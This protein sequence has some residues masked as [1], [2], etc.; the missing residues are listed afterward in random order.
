[1]N[2]FIVDN[3]M[4]LEFLE[5]PE[6]KIPF[7]SDS[8]INKQE[9]CKL[10]ESQFRKLARKYHPD[11]GGTNNDFKLLLDYKNKLLEQD[12]TESELLLSFNDSRFQSFDSNSMASKVG[13]QIFDLLS[14]WQEELGIKPLHRPKASEDEYEWIFKILDTELELCLNV[15]N[16]SEELAELSHDLYKDD[17][18]SI[19]V[20]LFFPSKKLAITNVAYD[21]SVILTFNDGILIESSKASDIAAYFSSYESIKSDIQKM[22]TGTFESK[23][24]KELKTKKPAKV[25]EQ[26]RKVLEYLQNLK[27][28]SGEYSEHAADFI[29]EL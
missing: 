3:Q 4:Y 20:C 19:L 17:S 12:R 6:S 22:I 24:N 13:D 21:D 14:G 5:I 16:L 25:I 26:D 28:F 18:L 2:Q 7:K 1:M 8:S 29:D 10:V 23:N 9:F 15:Q 11:Y 27:I